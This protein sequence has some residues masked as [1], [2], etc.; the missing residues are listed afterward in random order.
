VVDLTE[1]AY[2]SW[3]SDQLLGLVCVTPRGRDARDAVVVARRRVGGDLDRQA[4]RWARV[5][6]AVIPPDS[7]LINMGNPLGIFPIP[8]L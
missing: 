5:R 4:S 1:G 6:A 2:P 7:A 3:P 8:I